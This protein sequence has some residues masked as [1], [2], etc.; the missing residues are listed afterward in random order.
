M[1]SSTLKGERREKWDYKVVDRAASMAT[2]EK[3]LRELGREGWRLVP[4]MFNLPRDSEIDAGKKLEEMLI[5]EREIPEPPP[6]PLPQDENGPDE[7]H[8]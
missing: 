2:L 6:A 4:S 8:G 5:M 1:S 3:W 7:P